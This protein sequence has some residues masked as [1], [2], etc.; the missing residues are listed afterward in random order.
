[1][2]DSPKLVFQ[3]ISRD[4][5]FQLNNIRLLTWSNCRPKRDPQWSADCVL[6]VRVMF[7]TGTLKPEI[8]ILLYDQ[9]AKNVSIIT[10]CHIGSTLLSHRWKDSLLMS[11]RR[12]SRT[13]NVLTLLRRAARTS[14]VIEFAAGYFL[15]LFMLYW[16]WLLLWMVKSSGNH[17]W[18]VSIH[19]HGAEV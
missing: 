8:E 13:S 14:I 12:A 11:L 2:R 4:F 10:V 1:M 3:L 18:H 5:Y 9:N 7:I 16:I 6:R 15:R 19:D 17:F